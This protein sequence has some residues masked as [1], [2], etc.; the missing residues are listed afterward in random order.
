MAKTSESDAANKAGY[1]L[2][3]DSISSGKGHATPT[4]RERELARKQPL[5]SSD[6][7]AARKAARSQMQAQRERARIGMAAGEEKFLP[8]R[9]RG[10]QKRYVRDYV[11]ARFSVGE[12]L[13]PLMFVVI[14]LTFFPQPEVQAIGLVALWAFFLVAIID[15]VVLGFIVKRKIA[16]KFGADRLEKVRW[17]AA[18]RALQL[19]LMRLPKPQVKRGQFPV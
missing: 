2:N 3:Q 8:M 5:V 15:V 13:I 17:Y 19:R 1:E 4:R 9:D 11:D 16:A 7:T 18:M 14:I 10:P 6:R 12:L